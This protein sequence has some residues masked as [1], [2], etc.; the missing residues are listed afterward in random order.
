[1]NRTDRLLG[2][3]LELQRRQRVRAADLAARFETSRRTIYRDV[4]AL[5]E[6]G[7]PIIAQPG[8][9]YSLVEGYF[10]PPLSFTSDEATMLLLGA[11][12][13]AENFDAP[14]RDAAR[15]ATAKLEAALS[16][17]LREEVEYLR[18]S[19][20]FVTPD[21][22]NRRA[23]AGKLA[24]LRGALVERRTVRFRYHTRYAR[25]GASEQNVRDVD[26]YGLLHYGEA[27]YLVGYC[28]LRR[29]VRHFR[30]DRVSELKL[31]ERTF[32]RPRDF[33]MEPTAD[34]QRKIEVRAL[35]SAGVAPW[36]RESRAY[37]TTAVEE[38][39][40]GLLVTLRVRFESEVLPW[41]LGWGG[42]VR[43]L[44]PE[45]LRRRLAAE[46]E[47]MLKNHPA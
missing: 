45:S 6:T 39:P 1:M 8:L 25:E 42:E 44:E 20:S 31:L 16:P 5:S 21:T 13:V 35:F 40:A 37:F 26:P 14:Y 30:F 34:D 9:G 29:D 10:L 7:V 41:L 27:W 4:Q 11:E 46:A 19:I 32:E 38:A 17:R 23:A 22:L 18:R 43:V 36:V 24:Q 2:I 12:F 33:T 3:L 28:H 15:G 47:K